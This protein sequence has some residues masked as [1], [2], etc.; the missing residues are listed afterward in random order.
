MAA[1]TGP[2]RGGS[3]RVAG[4]TVTIKQDA[5][6]GISVNLRMFDPATDEAHDGAA[7]PRDRLDLHARVDVVPDGAAGLVNFAWKVQWTDGT[8]ISRRT[9]ASPT[10]LLVDLR[11][12][13]STTT[14]RH[15]RWR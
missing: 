2:A 12:T 4:Q 1:D 11:R 6:S 13:G 5:A 3:M 14:A 9:G 8:A 7:S 10:F 15:G